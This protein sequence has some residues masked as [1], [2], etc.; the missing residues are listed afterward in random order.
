MRA[1]RAALRS[2]SALDADA[3]ALAARALQQP[4]AEGDTG[5]DLQ[6]LHLREARAWLPVSAA[7]ARRVLGAVDPGL[8]R[9]LERRRLPA[10]EVR[11]A[12]ADAAR[13]AVSAT[14][15]PAGG[16]RPAG[17]AEAALASLEDRDAS[18][19]RALRLELRKR[20]PAL[21]PRPYRLANG[22]PE[23]WRPMDLDW[24]TVQSVADA[25]G[26]R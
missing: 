12:L 6:L 4:S 26:A 17:E 18:A 14:S 3:A 22:R 1:A 21:P 8:A 11:T 16:A 2:A 23:P 9:E 25:E 7:A 20:A 19:A 15:A 13:I 10:A 5:S 24:A